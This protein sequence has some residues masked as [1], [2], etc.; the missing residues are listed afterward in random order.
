[1]KQQGTKRKTLDGKMEISKQVDR[2]GCD[3]D[4]NGGQEWINISASTHP[5]VRTHGH[6]RTHTEHNVC[7]CSDKRSTQYIRTRT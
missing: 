3:L 6:T 1:M 4:Y 7:H 5:Q 2:T